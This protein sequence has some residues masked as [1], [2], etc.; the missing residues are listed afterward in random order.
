VDDPARAVRAL[1]SRRTRVTASYVDAAALLAS[2][3]LRR[4]SPR[5]RVLS[6][7][8]LAD[9]DLL[10][11]AHPSEPAWEQTTGVGSPRFSAP[12]IEAIEAYVR[13]GGGLLVLGETEH[14]KYG[15]NV[16]E[17]LAHFGVKLRNDTVQDLRAL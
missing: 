4:G 6:G 13:G 14:E 3:G 11:I 2:R 16:N 5:R 10:V 12:E 8:A 9:A 17:L 15:N 7:D 1:C